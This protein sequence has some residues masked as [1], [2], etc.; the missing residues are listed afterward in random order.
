MILFSF[1]SFR[2][3]FHLQTHTPLIWNICAT[4]RFVR[5]QLKVHKTFSRTGNKA[6]RITILSLFQGVCFLDKTTLVVLPFWAHMFIPWLYW[7][8]CFLPSLFRMFNFWPPL[9]FPS[10]ASLMFNF[11][12]WG[13]FWRGRGIGRGIRDFWMSWFLLF[14]LKNF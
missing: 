12:L 1:K 13:W 14:F 11:T 10:S 4:H 7:T 9:M 8:A 2:D 3:Y 6:Y 5:F